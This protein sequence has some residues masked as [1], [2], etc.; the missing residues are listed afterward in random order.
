MKSEAYGGLARCY[1]PL[2]L[3]KLGMRSCLCCDFEVLAQVR[4]KGVTDDSEVSILG[5]CPG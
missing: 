5:T 3:H 2:E 1:M 4:E